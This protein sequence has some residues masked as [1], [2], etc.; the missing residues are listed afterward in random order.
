MHFLCSMS[1]APVEY[2]MALRNVINFRIFDFQAPTENTKC[3]R[4]VAEKT[5]EHRSK[6]ER[7]Q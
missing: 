4:S 2:C 5:P 1:F 6:M 7:V 3:H